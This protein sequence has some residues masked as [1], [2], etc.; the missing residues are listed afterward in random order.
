MEYN[1]ISFAWHLA[2]LATLRKPASSPS[3]P[4]VS[5]PLKLVVSSDSPDSNL[6]SPT[7]N[8]PLEGK[9]LFRDFEMDHKEKSSVI[10]RIE[11]LENQVTDLHQKF[12]QLDHKFDLLLSMLT[13]L[14]ATHS[15]VCNPLPAT[16]I[17]LSPLVQDSQ[18]NNLPTALITVTSDISVLKRSQARDAH[19]DQAH[20]ITSLDWHY[21]SAHQGTT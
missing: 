16:E 11:I 17:M 14:T 1:D 12:D 15:V 8:I 9:A 19:I 21:F 10:S 18:V 7:E 6:F 2:A 4:T 13:P 3:T 5:I 20:C